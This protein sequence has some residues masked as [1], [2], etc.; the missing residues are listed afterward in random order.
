MSIFHRLYVNLV[1]LPMRSDPFDEHN[2][3]TIVDSHHQ[4]VIIPF[5]I[6]DHSVRSHNAG[7]RIGQA[8]PNADITVIP[9]LGQHVPHTLEE[10]HWMFGS[11]PSGKIHAHDW[12][13]GVT[14]V[15]TIPAALVAE[16][17]ERCPVYQAS[18][19]KNA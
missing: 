5:D 17:R 13:N 4:P 7:I 18:A 2:L 10:N 8:L 15:G 6:E 1:V 12:R 11:V 9:T 16:R 19:M 14:E 3:V